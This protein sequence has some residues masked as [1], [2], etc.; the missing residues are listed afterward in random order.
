MV[1]A[2]SVSEQL[3][4][5]AVFAV[6]NTPVDNAS[7]STEVEDEDGAAPVRSRVVKQKQVLTP[8]DADAEEVTG[9]DPT[10]LRASALLPRMASRFCDEEGDLDSE[11]DIPPVGVASCRQETEQQW[12]SY[13]YDHAG[14]PKGSAH[15]VAEQMH[16]QPT[17]RYAWAQDTV[18]PI[19]NPG[20]VN[21]M[22][23][24]LSAQQDGAVT[25]CVTSQPCSSACD[26]KTTMMIRNL[27]NKCSQV[28]LREEIDGA[29]LIGAYDFMHLPID[30]ETNA[31][32]GYAF[33]N[34]VTV[35]HAQAFARVFEGH[36]MSRF[37]SN[38]RVFVVPAAL[39]G[40]EANYAHYSSARVIR[41]DPAARPLFLREPRA[42]VALPG[43]KGLR[44]KEGRRRGRHSL[45]DAAQK[46]ISG[47]D[48]VLVVEKQSK[49]SF[50]PFCGNRRRPE[51]RFCEC[52]GASLTDHA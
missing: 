28:M 35:G 2:S 48:G 42:S 38:K 29:G 22:A 5:D 10:G 6:K 24:M 11:D 7:D 1:R 36:R 32:R 46:Q 31:N 16:T 4:R 27:P 44:K 50:C 18:C 26:D 49:P 19:L 17:R 43:R 39:Q 34:F 40:F 45:I 23:T 12:P 30:P 13:A 14:A 8:A 9:W 33:V 52:C 51:F 47:S 21:S 25:P 15:V 41:G 3:D 37:S 20:V